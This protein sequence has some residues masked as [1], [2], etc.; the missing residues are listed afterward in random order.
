MS[1]LEFGKK[2]GFKV[3]ENL[4][5]EVGQIEGYVKALNEKSLDDSG[6]SSE[7]SEYEENT[8][9]ADISILD[10][11]VNNRRHRK[12]EILTS[13][14]IAH[15]K[16]KV[17]RT[18]TSNKSDSS[19]KELKIPKTPST[20]KIR[21]RFNEFN[22]HKTSTG[23]SSSKKP[24]HVIGLFE[25][26][27]NKKIELIKK[28]SSMSNR[29]VNKLMASIYQ[30]FLNKLKNDEHCELI[31]VAYDE[32]YQKYGLRKVSDRKFLDFIGSLFLHS[33][34]LRSQMFLRFLECGHKINKSDFGRLSLNLYLNCLNFMLNSKI[35]IMT[36]Y[37]DSSESSYFP[38]I[39]AYEC[40]KEKLNFLEKSD[41]TLIM[42]EVESKLKPD[43]KKINSG[44]IELEVFLNIIIE[45]YENYQNQIIEGIQLIYNNISNGEDGTV[46]KEL[47]TLVIRVLNKAKN[48]IQD[49]TEIE[50]HKYKQFLSSFQTETMSLEDLVIRS[51]ENNLFSLSE[52]KAFCNNSDGIM[53]L[54]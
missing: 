2:Q 53:T 52:V 17:S 43:P 35:G 49:D 5:K 23:I 11:P 32:F 27:T 34:H 50:S 18:I 10:V 44:L 47:L 28:K 13:Q 40:V 31:E 48:H 29:L 1:G 51:I 7:S 20:P 54:N 33:E 37:E 46:S 16:L 38:I 36:N 45:H 22:F 9:R 39:R 6:L 25:K 3:G 42:T 8:S 26:F 12:S 15:Q 30:T 21:T 4:G 41:Y 19:V 14:F 24:H